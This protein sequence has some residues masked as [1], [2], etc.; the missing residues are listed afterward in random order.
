MSEQVWCL[1]LMLS[2]LTALPSRAQEVK[3]APTVAQCRADQASWFHELKTEPTK[4]DFQIMRLWGAEMEDCF[5]VDPD[6]QRSYST[7]KGM[8]AIEQMA[9]LVSYMGRHGI[10]DNFLT[11]DTAG[12]R[13]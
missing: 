4:T 11:E 8:I 7:T 2:L 3:H 12:K 13:R 10:Y 9:R 1:L 6:N 5:R